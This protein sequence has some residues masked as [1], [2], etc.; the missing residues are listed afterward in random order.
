[1]SQ[2]TSSTRAVPQIAFSANTNESSLSTIVYHSRAVTPLSGRDLHRLTQAAQARNRQEA[3]TGLML[4]DDD[5]FFQWLEGPAD[6]VARV[7]RSILNDPRHTA[8]E[9]LDEQPA[10]RRVFGEWDMKLAARGLHAAAWRREVIEPAREVFDHLRQQPEA[11]AAVLAKLV[12]FADG[13]AFGGA[14]APDVMPNLPLGRN[15]ALI[16][17]QIILAKVIPVLA[18]R[19]GLLK[20]A[21]RPIHP[22]AAELADLLIAS[23]ESAARQLIAELHTAEGLI[24]PLYANLF[25]PAARVLG[26]LWSEDFCSEF[27][28]TLGLCRLQSAARLLSPTHKLAFSQHR[29]GPAVLVAPEPGELHRLGAALDSEVLWHAGWS[30]TCEYPTDN[31]VLQDILSTS[32]FDALDVS[33]SAAFRREHWLPRLAETITDARRASR[34]PALVVLVGGR[35]FVDRKTTGSDV[36]ADMALTTAL[37]VDQSILEGLRHRDRAA[38]T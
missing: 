6:S 35:V 1:M 3:I 27:D 33:L 16:L 36:G 34:N 12:S 15:T 23:D 2:A 5:H 11:A 24:W 8:I 31:Q 32:W 29:S 28:V 10:S 38:A 26:D 37:H 21:E 20:T 9:V 13:A 19:N 4:Y 22:K 25:E 30:P 18:D 14:A 7:M 17:K